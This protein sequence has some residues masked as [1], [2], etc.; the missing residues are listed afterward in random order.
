MFSKNNEKPLR[1]PGM[2][3]HT[4]LVKQTHEAVLRNQDKTYVPFE[5]CCQ[6]SFYYI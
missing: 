3:A 4:I 1:G 2:G 6:F 5:L